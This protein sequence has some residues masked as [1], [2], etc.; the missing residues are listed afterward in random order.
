MRT[1]SRLIQTI[2]TEYGQENLLMPVV[3]RIM[4]LLGDVWFFCTFARRFCKTIGTLCVCM[5][6]NRY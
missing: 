5:S 3:S 6:C 4:P 1:E 2:F